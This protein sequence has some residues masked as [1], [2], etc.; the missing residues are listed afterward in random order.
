MTCKTFLEPA[1]DTLWREIVLFDPL[2]ACL[3]GDLWREASA[4]SEVANSIPN[5][6]LVST[7]L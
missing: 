2:I 1:L 4:E 7:R 6:I 3:P 5:V